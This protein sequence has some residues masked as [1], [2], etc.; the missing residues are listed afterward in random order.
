MTLPLELL[1][2]YVFPCY[3]SLDIDGRGRPTP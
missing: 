1:G 2:A 3:V